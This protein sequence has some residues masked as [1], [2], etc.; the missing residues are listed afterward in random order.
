[1]NEVLVKFHENEKISDKPLKFAVIMAKHDSKWI[2]CRHKERNTYEIPGG[3]KEIGED[4]DHTAE[5]E[6]SEETGAVQFSLECVCVYS[7]T[8]NDETTY[9]KLYFADI[10]ELSA[11]S[12]ESE[13]AEI[14]HF[15]NMPNELTYPTIQPF[16]YEK[17][18]MWLNLQSAR[19]EI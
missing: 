12:S 9:G 10:F 14:Y 3:H 5:R 1:M 18:Q 8:R 7:V 13:I 17:V 6:L 15:D 2:F 11:L 19:D 4:I 16:L